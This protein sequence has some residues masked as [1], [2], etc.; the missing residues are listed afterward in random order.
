MPPGPIHQHNPMR[1]SGD[2]AA[3]LVEMPL[4][5]LR[6]CPRQHERRPLAM[7]RADG[8]IQIGVLIAL[9]GGLAGARALLRPQ[10]R[11]AVLLTQPRFV[12]KPDFYRF[13][14]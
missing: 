4:H 1:L 5:G 12:L 11:Q 2:M 3:D 14:R 10:P 9:I 13:P 8:A 7:G 6:V